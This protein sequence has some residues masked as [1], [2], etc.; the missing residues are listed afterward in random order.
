MLYLRRTVL[1]ESGFRAIAVNP[2]GVEASSGSTTGITIHD[3]AADVAA[4]VNSLMARTSSP[5]QLFT[6]IYAFS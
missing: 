2:R 5:I 3:L 6:N 4:I 1:A